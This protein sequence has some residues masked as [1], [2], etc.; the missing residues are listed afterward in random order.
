MSFELAFALIAVAVLL[1]CA[2]LVFARRR[3]TRIEIQLLGI[4]RPIPSELQPS[5]RIGDGETQI[6]RPAIVTALPDGV[7]VKAVNKAGRALKVRAVG[8]DCWARAAPGK[9]VTAYERKART[10]QPPFELVPGGACEWRF[11]SDYLARIQAEYCSAIPVV[12]MVSGEW[13]WPRDRSST[14]DFS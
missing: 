10:F 9:M 12:E 5:D 6:Q 8:F 3:R 13:R 1:A 7:A 14:L 11:P 2:F 4:G